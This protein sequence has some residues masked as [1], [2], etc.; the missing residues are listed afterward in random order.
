MV[1][2]PHMCLLV[3]D[4]CSLIHHD[5]P[6]TSTRV[7]TCQDNRQWDVV[8]DYAVGDSKVLGLHGCSRET[9]IVAVYFC[10]VSVRPI[11]NVFWVTGN[12]GKTV[13]RGAFCNGQQWHITLNRTTE[14][15]IHTSYQQVPNWY[16]T[17]ESKMLVG[18]CRHQQAVTFYPAASSI[19]FNSSDR[20]AN[21]AKEN[22]HAH[23]AHTFNSGIT[24]WYY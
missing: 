6:Y 18:M 7:S 16:I 22:L 9:R 3:I 5:R 1:G 15:E 8:P 12:F 24:R 19:W 4:C 11:Y 2:P 10:P 21:S 20:K 17:V 23:H 13:C 14:K